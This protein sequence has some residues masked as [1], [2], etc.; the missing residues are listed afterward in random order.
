MQ[1]STFKSFYFPQILIKQSTLDILPCL[2]LQI[3]WLGNW[4]YKEY[5]TYVGGATSE[6]GLST[7]GLKYVVNFR[8]LWTLMAFKSQTQQ[9]YCFQSSFNSG[10]VNCTLYIKLNVKGIFALS[11]V[12]FK[13]SLCQAKTPY[14]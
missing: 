3:K 4:P 2:K 10:I 13:L 5:I 8:D 1:T 12:Y 6:S 7:I 9:Q 14:N 11:K